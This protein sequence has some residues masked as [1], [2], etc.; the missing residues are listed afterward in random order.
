MKKRKEFWSWD[1]V[2]LTKSFLK[3]L[4]QPLY[5]LYYLL[6]RYRI[7]VFH[8]SW[9]CCYFQVCSIATFMELYCLQL[10]QPAHAQYHFLGLRKIY[11]VTPAKQ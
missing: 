9:Q 3:N 7:W 2:T 1:K 5:M 8:N 10:S 4:L 11:W 6:T